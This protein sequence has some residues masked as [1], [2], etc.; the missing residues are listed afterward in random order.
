MV[1]EES[2]DSDCQCLSVT[3]P[4]KA[5]CLLSP[6]PEQGMLLPESFPSIN[7]QVSAEA[8]H[9]SPDST[10]LKTHRSSCPLGISTCTPNSTCPQWN[11]LSCRIPCVLMLA[12]V[13]N[14]R[15]P[16][17]VVTQSSNPVHPLNILLADLY[18]LPFYDYSPGMVMSTSLSLRP[19]TPFNL[20]F[21]TE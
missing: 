19:Y 15:M 7:S 14:S 18:F 16:S 4:G 6:R 21:N 11:H 17:S 12:G 3:K 1:G 9:L 8:H 20:A 2:G 13:T 10:G 5:L